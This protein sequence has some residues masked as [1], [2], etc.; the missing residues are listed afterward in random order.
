MIILLFSV[1]LAGFTQNKV[2][3]DINPFDM[4]KVSDNVNILFKK[5]DREK[6]TIVTKGI[7]YDKIVTETS[8]RLLRI[9]MKNGIFKSG[10]VD[11]E[12]EYVKLRSIEATNQAEIRFEEMIEGDELDLKATGGASIHV[13]LDIAALKASLSNGGR[14]EVK[15]K[16][17]LQ[18]VEANLGGSYNG[19]DFETQNGYVKSNTNSDVVVWVKNRLE[20]SAGS[21]AE[22]KY[23]GKPE[24]IKS[25]TSLGGRIE[26]NI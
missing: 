7:G 26:G 2:V 20:A 21:K 5:S 11:I 3:R 17:D 23:R 1:N 16:A 6:I 22:L 10:E 19:Y 18:E 4:V 8:G 13:E 25:S 9:K 24:E 14:I 12:V 15:G